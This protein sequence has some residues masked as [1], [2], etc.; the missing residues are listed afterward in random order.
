VCYKGKSWRSDPSPWRKP[1]DH[2][3]IP[4]IEQLEFDFD[5]YCALIFIPLEGRKYFSGGPQLRD[6]EL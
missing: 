1:E 2:E 5:C 4:D 6:F 3:W